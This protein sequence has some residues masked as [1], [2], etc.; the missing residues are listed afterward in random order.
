MILPQIKF[1]FDRKHTASSDK[2]GTIDIRITYG[3]KQKFV[4]TGVKCFPGQ[5]DAVHECVKSINAVWKSRAC[6]TPEGKAVLT[7]ENLLFWLYCSQ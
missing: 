2:K 7:P 6:L 1:I 5:W 4:A 3:S